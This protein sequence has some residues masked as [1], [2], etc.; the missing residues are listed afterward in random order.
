MPPSLPHTAASPPRHRVTRRQFAGLAASAAAFP[1]LLRAAP[2]YP[3]KPTRLIVPLGAGG[4]MDPLGRAIAQGLAEGLGQPVVVDN[5]PGAAGQIA[6]D[7]VAKTPGDPYNL[8]LGSMGIMSISPWLYPNLPYDVQR[9]FTP[10]ALCAEVPYALVVNPTVVPVRTVAEF[11][12]WAQAQ[13]VPVAYGSVGS[14][15]VAHIGAVMLGATAGLR[16]TQV[17]YRAPAQI[18]TDMVKGDLPMIFDSPTAY[19]GFAKEGRLRILA[20][21]SRER[22]AI[23]PDVPTMEESGIKGFELVS[24][25]G[26]YGPR[27][28]PA[29]VADRLRRHLD[30]ALRTRKLQDQFTPMGLRIPPDGAAD[31]AAFS[32]RDRIRWKSFI[33]RN[34]IKLDKA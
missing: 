13:K 18:A 28:L 29:P 9:D 33:E 16:M 20:V 2:D 26:L 1:S 14:G 34:D 17:P 27:D 12:Q 19:T 5:K 11:V 4:S 21:T 24:W 30:Q 25:F 6:A 23:L 31:F 8:I 22:M 3:S 32:E 7:A 10:L 15:S